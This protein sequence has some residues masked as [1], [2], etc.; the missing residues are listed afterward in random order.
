MRN[1]GL[2][3]SHKKNPLSSPFPLPF[4]SRELSAFSNVPIASNFTP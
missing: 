3:E 2:W 4:G 1:E